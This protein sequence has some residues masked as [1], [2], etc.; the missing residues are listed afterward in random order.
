M[1]AFKPTLDF[2]G[3]SATKAEQHVF[4]LNVYYL[5]TYSYLQLFCNASNVGRENH[6]HNDISIEFLSSVCM[7]DDPDIR[8]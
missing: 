8:G 5:Y 1:E 7:S 3:S 2:S 4:A 6:T